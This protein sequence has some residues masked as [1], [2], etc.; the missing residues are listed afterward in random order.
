[1]SARR[2][3]PAG[4]SVAGIDG[5]RGAWLVVR[6][7]PL[8]GRKDLAGA[9]ADRQTTAELVTDLGP[10]VDALRRDELTAVAI[11]M[12]IGLLD[13]HPR[14]CEVEARK[15]LGPRRSSVFPSPV[16]AVLDAADYDEARRISR[17]AVGKA[18]SRQAFNLVPAIRHLDRLVRSGD[19]DRLVEAHPELAFAR[20]AGRPLPHPKRTAEGRAL[21]RRLLLEHDPTLRVV[22]DTSEL[23]MID[24][25]D[26][27]ALTVTADRVVGA[28]E[29]RL[30]PEPT[31]DGRLSEIV[32]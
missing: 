23:P 22:L 11:D 4:G 2:P 32:W 25:L 27:A 20:L 26:A 24:L 9:A 17:A 7:G 8:D 31:P 21:R 30:G 5:C 28:E 29:R 3:R 12:P 18:P 19:Q 16:R 10:I 14:L 1:M 15:L 6:R 13:R